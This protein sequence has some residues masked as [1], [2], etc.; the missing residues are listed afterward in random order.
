MNFWKMVCSWCSLLFDKIND[1]SF[2]GQIPFLTFFS[3]F[4]NF[5]DII[6]DVNFLMMRFLKFGFYGRR[7]GTACL[8][9]IALV[10]QKCELEGWIKVLYDC[11]HIAHQ[12][13][14]AQYD[15]G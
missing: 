1:G 4:R 5:E 12:K 14:E 10:C 6:N 8:V 15:D 3:L 13:S 2:F 9:V 7:E 11:Y